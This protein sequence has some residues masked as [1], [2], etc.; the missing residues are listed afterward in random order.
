MCRHLAYLGAPVQLGALL[1]EPE[2]SLLRQ[3][4]EPRRQ[5]NGVVNA[6]G[7]GIGWYAEG[8]PIPARYRSE[9]PMWADPSLPDIARVVR[10]GAVLAAVRSATHP[11]WPTGV[12]AA[13]PFAA[14][15]HLFSHNGLVPGWPASAAVLAADLPVA[16]LLGT[17]SREAASD[18]ALLW[19]LIAQR[20]AAGSPVAEAVVDVVLH[21][22]ATVGGRLN[23]L[24][25]DGTQ[26]VAT[27]WGN[28]LSWRADEGGVVVASEPHDDA[29]GWVDVPDRSLVV[30]RPDGVTVEPLAKPQ[31]P[32]LDQEVR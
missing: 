9:R 17:L 1:L 11:E 19:A 31:D 30:A 27:T 21:T 29:A 10:S 13:A 23:L 14:G 28:T 5:L 7:F 20:L 16:E 22:A 2:H 6:D 26:I 24:L 8:D 4:W 25:T 3:S 12:G 15:R 32:P 18:S